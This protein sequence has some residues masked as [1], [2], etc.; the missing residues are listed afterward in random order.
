MVWPVL[1]SLMVKSRGVNDLSYQPPE[2]LTKELLNYWLKN[3]EKFGTMESIVEWWLLEH[4]IQ[5]ATE[6]VRFVLAD[7]VTKDFV[8]ER[9]QA[10]GRI[11]YQLNRQKESEIRAWL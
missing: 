7:L 6:E 2:T 3:A 1:C 10:D 11:S 4:R 8:L 5:K 9:Q